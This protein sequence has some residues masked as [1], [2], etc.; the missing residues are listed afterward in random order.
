MVDA[1]IERIHID[2][3]IDERLLFAHGVF[4]GGNLGRARR[5]IEDADLVVF[6]CH[7][8]LDLAANVHRCDVDG[9][10]QGDEVLGQAGELH[11]D[12][13]HDG[14]T[15]GRDERPDVGVLGGVFLF[16]SRID[17]YGRLRLDDMRKS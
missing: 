5:D 16:C 6:Q 2:D 12:E 10:P 13:A 11:L 14:R 9:R 7:V 1:I 4:H 15:E 3:T 17:R 8:F